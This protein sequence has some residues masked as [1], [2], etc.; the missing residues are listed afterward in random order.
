MKLKSLLVSALAVT[1]TLGVA[2][3]YAPQEVQAQQTQ[4]SK[5]YVQVAEELTWTSAVSGFGEVQKNAR[6]DGQ[7]ITVN[8]VDYSVNCIGTHSPAGLENNADIVY[9]ISAYSNNY[10]WFSVYVAQPDDGNNMVKFTVLVDGQEEDSITWRKS[11]DANPAEKHTFSYEP[12]RLIANVKG[13]ETLTLRINECGYGQP[14]GSSAWLN[15]I[16]YN[17]TG[18]KIWASDILERGKNTTAT[19]WDYSH[20]NKVILD[21][22]ANGDKLFFL[23]TGQSFEKGLGVQLRGSN[24]A[25]YSADK[26]NLNEYVSLKWDIEG[27]GYTFFNTLVEMDLSFGCYVD[28]WIDGVEVYH[29]NLINSNGTLAHYGEWLAKAPA[30]VNVAIPQNAKTFE[31]RVICENGIGDGLVNLCNAAFFTTNDYL[32]T[33]YAEETYAE[34]WPFALTRG[35]DHMGSPLKMHDSATNSSIAYPRGMFMVAG[36]EN[37]D[38]ACYSF[39]ITGKNYNYFSAK[40]GLSHLTT[41]L[42]DNTVNNVGETTFKADVVYKDGSVVTY[43]SQ[44]VNWSNSG[45]DFCF[46]YDNK[47]AVKLNLYTEAV[48]CGNTESVW[49]DAKLENKLT[50][51]YDVNGEKTSEVY[52]QGQELVKPQDPQV[53]GYDFLYWVQEG[54]TEEFNFQGAT[55][56]QTL[57]LVAIF[58]A[59]TYNVSYLEKLGENENTPVEYQPATFTFGQEVQLPTAK[60]IEGYTFKNWTFNGQVV[61]TM[62]TGEAKDVTL[63]AEY[64]VNTYTVKFIDGEQ[65]VKELQVNYGSTITAEEVENQLFYEFDGWYLGEEEFDFNEA[66]K[67]DLTLVAKWNPKSFNVTYKIEKKGSVEDSAYDYQVKTHVYGTTTTLPQGEEI[68]GFTF[69]G[70]YL[71]GQLVTELSATEVIEDVTLIGKYTVNVYNYVIKVDGVEI[72]NGQVEYGQTIQKPAD[73][74]KDGYTF[75]GWYVG[76]EEFDFNAGITSDVTIVA[77]FTQVPLTSGCS[78]SASAPLGLLFAM[79]IAL[80]VKKRK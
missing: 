26:T 22:K 49:G 72:L 3:A 43:T 38:N 56:T 23:G 78:S 1:M 60:E 12:V 77:S 8:G 55:V 36:D 4:P 17:A 19:G 37:F 29:S 70:W 58:Q 46:A 24:Y 44:L 71:D 47:D 80:V 42:D 21:G 9:D 30:S 13:A 6:W 39:D 59:K 63:V 51:N 31:L 66:V 15:P 75:D 32:Y 57:N 53:E 10:E 76:E 41:G 68:Q 79:G 65:T 61:N 5:T 34:V 64:T 27:K 16:L 25:N 2:M 20:G 48:A 35:Y 50:V 33:W 14:F 62:P 7:P 45:I 67:Q 69:G 28:A 54:Q 11:E 73:P 40:V 52:E 18:E 74:V